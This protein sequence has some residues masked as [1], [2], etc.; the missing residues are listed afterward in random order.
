MKKVGYVCLNDHEELFLLQRQALKQRGCKIVYKDLVFSDKE[1]DS[2][3][4]LMLNS[5]QQGDVV[6]VYD[7]NSMTNT[8]SHFIYFCF[9]ILDK[10]CYL[11]S[12]I[13]SFDSRHSTTKDVFDFLNSFEQH[14]LKK[15]TQKARV[16]AKKRGVLGSVQK[17]CL[18][19]RLQK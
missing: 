19:V 10:G 4:M 14:R 17:K 16:G 15:Q 6:I 2:G 8:L 13:D 9:S 1:H 12:V 5:I 11:E 18:I 3:F 7:L